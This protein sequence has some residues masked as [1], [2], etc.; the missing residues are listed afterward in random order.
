MRL[1][2]LGIFYQWGIEAQIIRARNVHIMHLGIISYSGNL[3]VMLEYLG[4]KCPTG[5]SATNKTYDDQ[6]SSVRWV[7]IIAAL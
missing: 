5:E 3:T 1:F 2:K 7:I 4:E 6:V